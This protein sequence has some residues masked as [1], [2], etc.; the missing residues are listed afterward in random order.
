MTYVRLC[1]P[2]LLSRFPRS[3]VR[4]LTRDGGKEVRVREKVR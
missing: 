2:R 4:R 1:M 3:Q